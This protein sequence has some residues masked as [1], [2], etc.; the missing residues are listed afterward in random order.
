MAGTAKPGTDGA[1]TPG[2]WFDDDSATFGDRLAA[3][4]EAAGL[5]QT[6]L[7]TRLGV[8]IA[9]L[10]N[11]END[12]SEPR[13]NRTQML[14]GMLGVSLRWLMSG[15]GPGLERPPADLPAVAA[16]AL[17][18]DLLRLRAA[19]DA[20]AADVAAVERRLARALQGPVP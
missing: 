4:R 3:A 11:W 15:E 14:A 2:T 1:T 8:N 10:R 17:R 18:A 13:S 5:T 16:G 19:A 6:E 20:L 9:T 12:R 7:A